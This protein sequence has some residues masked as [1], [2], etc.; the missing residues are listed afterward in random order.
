[1]KFEFFVASRYLRA[2][3]KQAVIGVITAIST[4]GVA[5]GV[6]ALIIAWAINNGFQQ[7]LERQLL[8]STSQVNLMRT[9]GDGIADWHS[10]L[11]R[12]EKQPHV[13]A[14]APDIYEQVLISLGPRA[15]GAVLKGIVPQ[16]ERKV[17]DLLN[18]VKEGSAEALEPEPSGSTE[19]TGDG[20]VS[21][22]KNDESPDSLEAV[23][24]RR[25]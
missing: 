5:A 15:R 1:M 7:S 19:S 3:R 17:S 20:S 8:G 24:Q 21:A 14:A 12:L 25:E 9:L 22:S 11:Q 23:Q 18:S 2:K 6:A 10:L 13:V 4:A 16:D